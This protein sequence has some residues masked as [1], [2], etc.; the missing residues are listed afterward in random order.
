MKAFKLWMEQSSNGI[1]VYNSM[2]EE[3]GRCD[4][5]KRIA[6]IT[7]SGKIQYYVHKGY[8]PDGD[9]EGIEKAA[10]RQRQ[11]FFSYWDS[12]NDIQKYEKLLNLCNYNDFHEVVLDKT[13]KLSE[14]VKRLEKRL[15]RRYQI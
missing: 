13:M 6:H 4:G 7:P 12:L 14:K 8:I 5:Y 15:E 1:T 3:D 2:D 10:E 11:E 9:K